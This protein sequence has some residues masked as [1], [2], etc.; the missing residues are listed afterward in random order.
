MYI[1]FIVII[2]S[3]VWNKCWKKKERKKQKKKKIIR[4]ENNA[5]DIFNLVRE[6]GRKGEWEG[7]TMVL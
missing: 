3:L 2:Y 6:K 7:G 1:F 4:T 5:D